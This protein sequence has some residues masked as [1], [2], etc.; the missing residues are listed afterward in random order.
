MSRRLKAAPAAETGRMGSRGDL[1]SPDRKAER[2]WPKAAPTEENASPS[3]GSSLQC[4]H[5]RVM[6]EKLSA[7]FSSED[8]FSPLPHPSA[9][10]RDTAAATFP[11]VRSAVILSEAQRSRRISP[12]QQARYLGCC[13]KTS[14]APSGSFANAQDDKKVDRPFVSKTPRGLSSSGRCACGSIVPG[15]VSWA[16]TLPD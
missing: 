9:A 16:A 1:R 6:R 8:R 7:I 4:A 3:G 11:P 13:D 2:K 12:P 15:K 10:S 5:W 14:P